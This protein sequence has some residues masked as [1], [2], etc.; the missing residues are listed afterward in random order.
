MRF[1]QLTFTRFIAAMAVLVFHF[2]R[3]AG[4][5]SLPYFGRLLEYANSLLSF[6]FVLTGFV[7]IISIARFGEMPKKIPAK[8]FW[9]NRFFRIYPLHI[10]AL[11]LTI[12]L[13]LMVERVNPAA[14]IPPLTP[15][16]VLLSTF[17]L[18]AWYP[19]YALIYNYVSWTLCVEVM[20]TLLAPALYGWMVRQ[21]TPVLMRN[22]AIIWLGSIGIHYG[23]LRAGMPID[24][25]FYF[26]VFHLPEFIVGMGGGWLIVR[27]FEALKATAWRVYLTSYVLGV[28]M[29]VMMLFSDSFA[30]KNSILFAPAFTVI[31]LGA[32]LSDNWLMR[33]FKTRPLRYLGEI[34]Y[35]LFILQVPISI[36]MFYFLYFVVTL[37]YKIVCVLFLI[38][39]IAVSAAVYEWMEKPIRNFIKAQFR[40]KM[41]QMP[42]A[43][44]VT[45]KATA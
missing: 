7:M 2:G 19:P 25:G 40:K 18:H 6:F 20:L 38:V 35:G 37:P 45:V 8:L 39:L 4:M 10:L 11:A 42:A 43:E 17:L 33:L 24:W 12:F 34:S 36:V 41:A 32:C 14:N 22:I 5:L 23:C 31:L 29:L 9:L 21:S 30:F 44:P 26:P 1:D 15:T 28:L 13:Q 16:K 27:H 3:S